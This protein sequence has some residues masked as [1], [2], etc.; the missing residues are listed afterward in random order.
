MFWK[1]EKWNESRAA[2]YVNVTVACLQVIL[3][4]VMAR[5]RMRAE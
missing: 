4:E 3:L 1:D 2:I 5:M